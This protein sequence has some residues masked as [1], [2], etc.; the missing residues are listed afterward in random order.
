MG[1][2]ERRILKAMIVGETDAE[3]LAVLGHE[4]S[5]V[6]TFLR[7]W[8]ASDAEQERVSGVGREAFPSRR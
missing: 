3:K 5:I 8:D 7:Q 4:R 1:V 6:D 2:S